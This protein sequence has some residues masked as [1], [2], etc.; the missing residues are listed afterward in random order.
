MKAKNLS[1]KQVILFLVVN[2]DIVIKHVN[3]MQTETLNPMQ[4]ITFLAGYYSN[5]S[6][7]WE[8]ELRNDF[9]SMKQM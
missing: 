6:I 3:V 7:M 2:Q 4:A 9:L 8:I 1:T 5:P